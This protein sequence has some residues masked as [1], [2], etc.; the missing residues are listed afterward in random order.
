MNAQDLPLLLVWLAGAM[1]LDKRGRPFAA[2][3]LLSLCSTKVHLFLP[4]PVALVAAGRR[5]VLGG[6]WL[7]AAPFWRRCRSPLP[8]ALLV[9]LGTTSLAAARPAAT[10]I[11]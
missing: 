4:L 6:L 2:G 3:M 5:S 8:V 9:L 1:A 11:S 7:P 10:G